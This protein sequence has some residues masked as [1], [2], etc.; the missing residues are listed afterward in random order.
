MIKTREIS[1]ELTISAY[2]DGEF[3]QEEL[4]EKLLKVLRNDHWDCT[5]AVKN[6]SPEQPYNG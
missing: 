2:Y 5:L 4:R 3:D 1:L 6:V